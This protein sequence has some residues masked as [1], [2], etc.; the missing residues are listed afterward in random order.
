MRDSLQSVSTGIHDMWYPLRCNLTSQNFAQKTGRPGG[1][2]TWWNVRNV[3][4]LY[5]KPQAMCA[6]AAQTNHAE[7]GDSD[8]PK[9]ST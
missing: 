1:I 6:H 2:H 7:K 4:L 8:R 5:Y 9:R 3:D